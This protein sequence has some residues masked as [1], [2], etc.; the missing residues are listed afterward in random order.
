MDI[1][2][3]PNSKAQNIKTFRSKN[4]NTDIVVKVSF[5]QVSMDKNV[6]NIPAYGLWNM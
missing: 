1:R 4:P 2:F 3:V 6:L 5:N